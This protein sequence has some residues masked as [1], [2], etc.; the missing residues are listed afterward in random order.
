LRVTPQR[1]AIIGAF[2]DEPSEHLSADE[3]HA[4]AAIAVPEIS[5]GTVYAA[6]AELTELGLLSAHGNPEPIRYEANTDPHQHFRCRLCLRIFDVQIPEPPTTE[7]VTGGFVVEAVTVIAEGVCAECGDYDHGL[8]A[9]AK[10]ARGRPAS[11]LPEGLTAAAMTTPLGT[12]TLGAT[13]AGMVRVVFD[14]HADVPVLNET[15]R[16]RRG[17]K[18]A[19]AHIAAARTA[20]ETYFAGGPAGNVTVDWDSIDG[21]ATLQ[22]TA[23]IAPGRDLSYEG[24]DSP[25][26]PKE[27]GLSLGSNPLA[28]LV[29]CHRVTRGSQI[30]EEYVGGA[31][32]RRALRELERG[33]LA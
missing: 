14:N 26:E 4:R 2:T 13:P 20:I 7:L 28:I 5:R 16:G 19:R 12:L 24:L 27:R 9:G 32:A 30:P 10:R 3:V 11:G 25:A 21:A 17:G 15:I 8:H 31:S 18:A 23:V 33:R 1:R 6:L 29:P 22:A